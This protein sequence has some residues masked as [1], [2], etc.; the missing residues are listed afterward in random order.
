[1]VEN[2]DQD[3]SSEIALKTFATER[4]SVSDCTYSLLVLPFSK[5]SLKFFYCRNSF[6]LCTSLNNSIDKY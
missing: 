4:P 6:L 2:R 3:L 1:M 5:K